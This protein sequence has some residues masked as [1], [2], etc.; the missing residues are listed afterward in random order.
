MRLFSSKEHCPFSEDGKH[1]VRVITAREASD[2]RE[3]HVEERCV[4]CG[5]VMD[6]YT[7]H[8]VNIGGGMGEWK[9]K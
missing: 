9:R 1:F 5:K 2:N 7:Q 4:E 6:A 8:L 3:R